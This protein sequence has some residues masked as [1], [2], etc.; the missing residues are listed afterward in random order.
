MSDAIPPEMRPVYCQMAKAKRSE[1]AG[2]PPA[3]DPFPAPDLPAAA[4]LRWRVD[5]WRRERGLTD[6]AR[7]AAHG[8]GGGCSFERLDDGGDVWL[9]DR[10]GFLHHCTELCGEREVDPSGDDLICPISGRCFQRWLTPAEEAGGDAERGQSRAED[11]DGGDWNVEEGMGGAGRGPGAAGGSMGRLEREAGRRSFVAPL[12]CR[13]AWE[14][15]L[16]RLQLCGR[17]GAPVQVWHSLPLKA[18][19][20]RRGRDA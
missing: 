8:C 13:A 6:A 14:G 17:G 2:L 12:L 7:H 18:A 4:A 1:G 3:G 16:R 5:A 9:C 15:I 20:P 11:D 10:S 19:C